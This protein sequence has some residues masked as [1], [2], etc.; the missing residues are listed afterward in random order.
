[1]FP[2]ALDEAPDNH[3]FLFGMLPF[4]I[5][6]L[7]NFL[8]RLFYRRLNK[9][10]GIDQQH[11]GCKRVFPEQPSLFLQGAEHYL[12]IN[13][14]FGAAETDHINGRHIQSSVCISSERSILVRFRLLV[15]NSES[16][17][18]GFHFSPQ[19]SSETRKTPA[20]ST[21]LKLQ[22][23][24]RAEYSMS[25]PSI[26][27]SSRSFSRYL[28]LSRY[29]ASVDQILPKTGRIFN[30][31]VPSIELLV[32]GLRRGGRTVADIIA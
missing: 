14:I 21:S 2:I 12:G 22:T 16:L 3:D 9:T 31:C 30:S 20:N 28:L 10:A 25:T 17:N 19:S 13:K 15:K 7:Q 18:P 29:G 32:E 4:D 26:P 27:C 6:Q 24:Q 8:N 1:M 11:L 5:D 23:A